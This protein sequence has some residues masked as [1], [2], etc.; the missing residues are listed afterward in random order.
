MAP[1]DPAT[2]VVAVPAVVAMVAPVAMISIIAPVGIV[3]GVLVGV[4][5]THSIVVAHVAPVPLHLTL[6]ALHL[7][8]I[9]LNA[10]IVGVLL[11]A[12]LRCDSSAAD[13]QCERGG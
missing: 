9:A 4:T 8:L 12:R 10:A 1:L 3:T 2:A 6:V 11:G 5:L 13:R 7:A